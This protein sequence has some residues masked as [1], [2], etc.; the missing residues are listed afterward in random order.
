MCSECGSVIPKLADEEGSSKNHAALSPAD[1]GIVEDS[2][3]SPAPAGYPPPPPP[4]GQSSASDHRGFVQ[5]GNKIVCDRCGT[6]L[7]SDD[8]QCP[9]CGN[10][11]QSTP[12][13]PVEPYPTPP[14]PHKSP[15]QPYQPQSPYP[16]P[17]QPRPPPP[18]QKESKKAKFA[19]CAKCGTIVYDYET[20]CNN[21]GRVLSAP[22]PT[23]KAK[24]GAP[25][26]GKAPPGTA[27][28]E[29][30][31]AIVYPHQSMCPNCSR[32]LAPVPAQQPGGSGQRISRCRRCGNT[33]YPTDTV[34]P[35][36][37]RD[38]DVI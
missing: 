14:P 11:I 20:K 36:C 15:A 23:G 3:R 29:R 28:C 31:N 7:R 27:R 4:P 38:L 37:G 6:V 32:P 22:K 33:V 18:Q 21:C 5:A 17:Q 9:G 10:P 24:P 25:A 35:N 13:R 30:C 12:Y 34:C 2:Y 26:T 1:F 16:P 8:K 19:K